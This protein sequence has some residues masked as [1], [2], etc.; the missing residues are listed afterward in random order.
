MTAN[1]SVGAC[2]GGPHCSDNAGFVTGRGLAIVTHA[3]AIAIGCRRH[4]R[5]GHRHRLSSSMINYLII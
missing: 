4:H 3:M 5:H 1:R 2:F